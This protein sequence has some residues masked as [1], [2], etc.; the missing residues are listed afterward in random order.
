MQDRTLELSAAQAHKQPRAALAAAESARLAEAAASALELPA[1]ERR[2]LRLAVAYGSWGWSDEGRA[3]LEALAARDAS[4]RVEQLAALIA[5][6]ESLELDEAR[7]PAERQATL[8]AGVCA[9]HQVGRRCGRSLS[10]SWNTAV[11]WAGAAMDP[12]LA[13]ALAIALRSLTEVAGTPRAA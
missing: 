10:E 6:G 8:I 13:D 11:A 9:R 3:A 2:L 4:R 7:T 5:R 1:R 12:G